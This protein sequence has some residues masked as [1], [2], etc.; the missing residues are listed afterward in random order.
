MFGR[1]GSKG[2]GAIMNKRAIL[3]GVAIAMLAVGAA[4]GWHY[5]PTP[6]PMAARVWAFCDQFANGPRPQ[7]KVNCVVNLETR[8]YLAWLLGL[9]DQ[10]CRNDPKCI[11]G[12]EAALVRTFNFGMAIVEDAAFKQCLAEGNPEHTYFCLVRP[13]DRGDLAK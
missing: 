3:M 11:K 7:F 8:G 1:R 13:G 6:T 2:E 9:A 10:G 5:W 4:I 12:Q